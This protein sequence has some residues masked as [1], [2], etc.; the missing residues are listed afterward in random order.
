MPG[1]SRFPLLFFLLRA[2]THT[3]DRIQNALWRIR[4]ARASGIKK[5]ELRADY[6][7]RMGDAGTAIPLWREVE[8]ARPGNPKWPGLIARAESERGDFAAAERTLLDARER[9]TTDALTEINVLR[10]GRM[11]RRSNAAIADAEAIV[12]DPA[13]AA[14]QVYYAAYYLMAQNRLDIARKGFERVR[15]D[16]EHGPIVPGQ[17]AALDRLA[18]AKA[19]GKPEISGWLSPVENS[20]L[21]REPSSDTLVVGFMLPLG[22]LALTANA[23]HEMLSSKG[24]NALYLYDSQQVFHLA[25]TDRFGP[26]YQAMIDGIRALAKELGVKRIITM[27][28]SATGFTA[29]RAGLDLGAEGALTFSGQTMMLSWAHATGARSAHTLWR[30]RDKV[31]SQMTNLQAELRQRTPPLRMEFYYSGENRMDRMHADNVR[32]L[33][34]VRLYPIE[35]LKR[36]DCLSEMAARGY[37][38]LLDG[39]AEG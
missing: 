11:V 24:V 34:G 18:D 30:L 37:R 16:K 1:R 8:R 13:S 28:G 7:W 9:G 33:P 2:R 12:T 22:T 36:H 5:T 38:D 3:L 14:S 39:F 17:I 15:G 27:G 23:V 29:L 35:G 21:V 31:F 19:Q 10:Y 32:G 26:G 25:G 4:I 20:V 6:A